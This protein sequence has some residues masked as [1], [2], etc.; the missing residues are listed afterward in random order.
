[1]LWAVSLLERFEGRNITWGLSECVLVDERAVYATAGGSR[2]LLVAF[3]KR[4]GE[5]IWRSKPFRDPDKNQFESAGYASP[6]LVRYGDR[7][8]LIG[9]SQRHLFCADANTGA[10]QWTVPRPTT[11]SVLA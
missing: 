2:A 7:R 1:E 9:T 6:I 3:D 8:L 11:Y 10:I 5:E 4:S